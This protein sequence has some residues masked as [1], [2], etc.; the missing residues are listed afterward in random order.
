MPEIG[1]ILRE[2]K[3]KKIY[4]TDDPDK[5]I[6]YFKDEAMAFHGLKRGR[7]LGKGEV[8]NSVS[9]HLF[10]LLKENGIENHY[11]ER[12]RILTESGIISQRLIRLCRASMRSR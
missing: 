7:I 8:N 4:A 10:H 1:M 11:L 6:V 2:G 9:E 12:L 5:A 3:G